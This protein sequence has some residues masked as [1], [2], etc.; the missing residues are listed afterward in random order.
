MRL[1]FEDINDAKSSPPML[2]GNNFIRILTKSN[3]FLVN[4]SLQQCWVPRRRT[5]CL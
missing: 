3:F 5:H 2:D 1:A 4:T